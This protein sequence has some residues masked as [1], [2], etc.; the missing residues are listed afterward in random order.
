MKIFLRGKKVFLAFLVFLGNDEPV[1]VKPKYLESNDGAISF[2]VSCMNDRWYNKVVD[3]VT[4]DSAY[5]LWA[6]IA[7][8]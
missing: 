5:A 6:K 2:M 3:S 4:M 7:E 1:K 8:K